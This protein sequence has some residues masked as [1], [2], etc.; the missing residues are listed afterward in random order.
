MAII[1]DF[2]SIC[3]IITQ[4]PDTS[5]YAAVPPSDSEAK[6]ETVVEVESGEI[7]ASSACPI[8]PTRSLQERKVD[9]AEKAK[10]LSALSTAATVN[11][12]S[13]DAPLPPFAGTKDAPAVSAPAG[14]PRKRKAPADKKAPAPA[15]KAKAPK[16]APAPKKRP[17][18]APAPAVVAQTAASTKPKRAKL[19]VLLGEI[20]AV[21][22]QDRR[23]I[24]TD[25]FDGDI[26]ELL[27][28]EYTGTEKLNP[29]N[30]CL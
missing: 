19:G 17:A 15:K 9:M 28:D 30:V 29:C 23:T 10:R 21:G 2:G 5:R 24:E 13:V 1:G 26:V 4:I 14:E 16:K 3:R 20:R 18:P 22:C 27:R 6:A 7:G 12:A 11:S 8:P 25:V